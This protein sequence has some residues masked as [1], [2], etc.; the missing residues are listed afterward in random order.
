VAW[1]QNGCL[2]DVGTRAGQGEDDPAAV[3]P[4]RLKEQFEEAAG[5]E[6]GVKRA[7]L[8]GPGFTLLRS[9]F[10]FADRDGDGR[11]TRAELER[12]LR[13]HDSAAKGLATLWIEPA[14]R[15]WFTLLDADRDGQLSVYEL[16]RAW[17][18]LSFAE[19]E[20]TGA[21]E[22]PD[23]ARPAWTLTLIGGRSRDNGVALVRGAKPRRGPAWFQAMDRNGD[24]FVSRREF[25]GSEE[26]FARLDRDK[27]GL[28]SPEEAAAAGRPSKR[29]SSR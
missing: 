5:V 16:R 19:A 15:S 8:A 2:L 28:I 26:S 22:V 6:A 4:R 17:K 13:L 23:F 25:V 7:A 27:D 12:F 29:T 18:S 9:V 21:L 24:G 3:D 11:L 20:K 1:K 10:P 14:P